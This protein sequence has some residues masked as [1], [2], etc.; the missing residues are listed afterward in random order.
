VSF[1]VSCSY[2]RSLTDDPIVF[3]SQPGA[4]HLHDFFGNRTVDAFSTYGS[5]VG[6]STS[7]GNPADTAGYWAPALFL[8]GVKVN[9]D[10]LK[11]YYYERVAASAP[12][13]PGLGV[14]AGNS[15]STA[16]QSTNRV[17]FGC[18]NGS[19]ISKVSAPPNCQGTGGEFTVHVMFP[20]CLDPATNG[21]A[22]PP[23]ASGSVTLPQL[24]ERISYPIIDA[25]EITLASG[26]SYTYH[27]DF[28]NS[29]D[30]ESLTRLLYGLPPITAHRATM[31]WTPRTPVR[32]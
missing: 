29:W 28:F 16:P 2:T 7:C 23:C 26:P 4:S 24:V 25:R 27:A 21:V 8:N 17:Y 14:V 22:Y 13:P 1:T 12:F 20:Y 31:R 30:Q 15:H 9:P 6:Q 11:A 3:P 18:G 5:L 19:G 10:D 32:P